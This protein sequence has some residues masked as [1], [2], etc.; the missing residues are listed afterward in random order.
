MM[1][2]EGIAAFLADDT[3]TG[4]N[5]AARYE[6]LLGRQPVFV[7]CIDGQRHL[8]RESVTIWIR[9]KLPQTQQSQAA[10]LR[11]STARRLS[12]QRQ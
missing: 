4:A 9:R 11:H 5:V 3:R 6:P 12:Q 1:G 7:G 2:L 8:G 10:A